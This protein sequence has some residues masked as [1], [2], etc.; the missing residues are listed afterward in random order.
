MTSV[1]ISYSRKD[2]AFA[3]KIHDCLKEQ[4]WEIWI[5]RE[6][7][8]PTVD[9]WKEI[10][11]GIETA[12]VFLFLI[13]PDSAA[14]KVCRQEI[15]YAAKNNKRLIPLVV[16]DVDGDEV[17]TELS[18]L[19]WI[20]FRESD[21]FDQSLHKLTTA[22]RTDYEWVQTHRELQSKA[23]EWERSRNDKSFL[24][25]GTELQTAEFQLASNSS[26]EPHPTD[27]QRDYVLKSRQAANRQRNI[28]NG[29]AIVVGTVITVL[30]IFG[31][32]TAGVATENKNEAFNNLRTAEAAST[33][34]NAQRAA[35]QANAEEARK[36]TRLARNGE[37]SA[38]SV[39]L[40]DQDFQL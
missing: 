29:I 6:G 10:E 22:V 21:D 37:L 15:E 23:L 1:F 34:A 3:H 18:H 13:S 17:P 16:R 7:I 27:L 2:S 14:S 28:R 31:W 5:D 9:W 4:E 19:N 33:L 32:V 26:K 8:A 40:R 11:K 39:A 36:Q 20:F 35:A 30:G 25:Q 38:Q 24:L 12:G